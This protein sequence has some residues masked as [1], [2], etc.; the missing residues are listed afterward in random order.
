MYS[1][2]CFLEVINGVGGNNRFRKFVPVACDSMVEMILCNIKI[3]L[4]G[5][6]LNIV[7]SGVLCV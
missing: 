6:K 3:K 5:L 1:A 7:T 4:R 2:K